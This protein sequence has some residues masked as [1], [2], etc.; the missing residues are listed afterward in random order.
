MQQASGALKAPQGRSTSTELRPTALKTQRSDLLC[1]Q[2]DCARLAYCTVFLGP[3]FTR[4]YSSCK[5]SALGFR[6][7]SPRCSA[8]LNT[9]KAEVLAIL[10]L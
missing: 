8:S 9:E 7:P 10:V 6:L 5:V 4:C 1:G 3:Q 2:G